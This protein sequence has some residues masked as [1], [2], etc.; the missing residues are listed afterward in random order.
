MIRIQQMIRIY[1]ESINGWTLEP[2]ENFCLKKRRPD[3]RKSLIFSLK[4]NVLAS[5]IHNG[6]N[7]YFHRTVTEAIVIACPTNRFY[8]TPDD[9]IFAPRYYMFAESS[10]NYKPDY[11]DGVVLLEVDLL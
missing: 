3:G 6:K 11:R 4:E 7:F 8:K 1:E 10:C 5:M 2:T 9:V